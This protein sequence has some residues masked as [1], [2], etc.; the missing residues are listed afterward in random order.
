MFGLS[1]VVFLA[2]V[3]ILFLAQ[4]GP[5][6][7]RKH[8]EAELRDNVVRLNATVSGVRPKKDPQ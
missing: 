3:G 4:I 8:A 5:I 1:I 7:R 6:K 2:I